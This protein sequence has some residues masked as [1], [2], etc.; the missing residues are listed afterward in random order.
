MPSSIGAVSVS[1]ARVWGTSGW[2]SCMVSC[3]LAA[4]ARLSMRAKA[5]KKRRAMIFVLWQ[6]RL[7]DYGIRPSIESAAGDTGTRRHVYS[8]NKPVG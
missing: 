5:G 4:P 2:D 6:Y 1:K 8:A 3:P 7:V